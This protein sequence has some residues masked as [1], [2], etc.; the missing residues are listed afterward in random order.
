[1]AAL[2]MSLNGPLAKPRS[3]KPLLSEIRYLFWLSTV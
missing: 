1:V 2:P 3:G